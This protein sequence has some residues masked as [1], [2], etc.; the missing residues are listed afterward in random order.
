PGGA[1]VVILSYGLWQKRFGGEASIVN[2]SIS[3]NDRSYTV[4]GVMP[5]GF[6]F[7]SHVEIWVPVGQLSGEISWQQRGNHPGLYGIARLKDG[8][9]IEQARAEMDNIAAGLEQRYRDTNEGCRVRIMPLLENY[10]RDVRQ[11]LWILFGAVGF[12][13]LIACA[14]VANLTLARATMRQKELAVRAALGAGRWRIMRQLLTE[15]VLLAVLGGG[16]GLLLAQWCVELIL[17]VSPDGIPRSQE[18]GLDGS[19]LVFTML[20]SM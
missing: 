19:V 9:R 15:S 11:R 20:V 14:N 18:V 2:R 1:A 4:I 6:K 10:V 17:K 13:L 3:L 8:I 5:E 7:P 16:F 12:V